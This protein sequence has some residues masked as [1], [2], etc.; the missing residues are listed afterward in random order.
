MGTV[1]S[2]CTQ[3]QSF[4]NP[5]DK[6]CGRGEKARK[7][8]EQV[9][10]CLERRD[11]DEAH[12]LLEGPLDYSA[13]DAAGASLLHLAVAAGDAQSCERL[14]QNCPALAKTRDRRGATPLHRLVVAR[15][16]CGLE[17]CRLLIR[18]R[19]DDAL[20]NDEGQAAVDLARGADG[21]PEVFRLLEFRRV[22]KQPREV[23][24][25]LSGVQEASAFLQAYRNGDRR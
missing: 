2:H 23:Q 14:L 1:S 4:S 20:R 15:P 5:C 21:D 11:L 25:A 17:I 3:L 16:A 12:V 24:E 6:V 13:A 19:V 10:V 18:A 22:N 7:A 9:L 8:G